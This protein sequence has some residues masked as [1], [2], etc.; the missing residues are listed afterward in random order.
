[1]LNFE[2]DEKSLEVVIGEMVERIKGGEGGSMVGLVVVEGIGLSR[3]GMGGGKVVRIT[4]VVITVVGMNKVVV[5][6]KT[7]TTKT[8]QRR[9]VASRDFLFR[10]R[11]TKAPSQTQ[12]EKETSKIY[13]NGHNRSHTPK[14]RVKQKRRNSKNWRSPPDRL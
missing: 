14:R 6:V 10:W 9:G 12:M 13:D 2:N 4:T 7:S 11:S 5:V 8:G 1:V 3:T